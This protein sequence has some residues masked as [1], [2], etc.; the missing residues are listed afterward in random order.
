MKQI[1]FS[2]CIPTYN[3]EDTI[4]T[5]IM[6][7]INQYNG[8][9][10]I[11]ICDDNSSDNTYNILSELS[12]NY[13][14]IK[15]LRN[16]INTGMDANFLKAAQ[17]GNGRYIWLFGQ[18]DILIPGAINKITN[19]LNNNKDIGIVYINYSQYD[20]YFEKTICKSFLEQQ[21]I[22]KKYK[23]LLSED[24]KFT[25]STE[26]FKVLDSLPS[27]LPAIIMKKQYWDNPEYEKFKG[28]AYIQVGNMLLNMNKGSIYV[29]PKVYIKGRIPND[30]WQSDG[31]KHFEI[32][33]GALKMLTVV[34]N[35]KRNPMPANIYNFH[36]RRYILNYFFLVFHCKKIGLNPNANHISLLKYI[37][38]KNVILY[39][40]YIL[41][42]LKMP[43][44]I[45]KIIGIPLITIKRIS[46]YFL[47]K[48]N[49]HIAYN[50]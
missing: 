16:N 49:I 24:I 7:I 22:D 42:I 48:S 2:I 23:Y 5:T 39:K 30:R 31:N 40:L 3:G 35:D 50:S 13:K 19:I 10:N 47:K 46:I 21:L 37:F 20:H 28:T 6:S 1:L 32:L 4:I 41:P 25:N 17:N 43:L 14:Y 34:Y 11:V 45:M 33:T 12:R 15:I 27:F 44:F 29:V 8:E 18:D 9:F 26:Y 36:K 38:S